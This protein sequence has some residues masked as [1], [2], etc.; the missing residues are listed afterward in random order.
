MTLGAPQMTFGV[1]LGASL[2]VLGCTGSDGETGASVTTGAATTTGSGSTT[3]LPTDSLDD[4]DPSTL[5]AGD[6]P[7]REPELATVYDVID[8]DTARME[9]SEGDRS[10]RFI[11]IDTTEI[12][13][14][15]EPSECYAEEARDLVISMLEDRRV[16]LTFD[17][18][19]EDDYD[20]W[21]AYIHTGT[22]SQGFVQRGLLQGGYA[23]AFPY[24]PN[25]TFEDSFDADEAA[26]RDAGA[27]LWGACNR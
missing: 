11:G 1:L 6:S 16:W 4:I 7:C 13:Y 25:T 5:P 15:G 21:L 9:T 26:A 2:C 24:H 8:G 22:S 14:D 23:Y 18:E 3:S 12:G 10:V 20:R 17:A 27:G 19:C